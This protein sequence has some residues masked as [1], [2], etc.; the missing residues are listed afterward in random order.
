MIR[1]GL[2][3]LALVAGLIGTLWALWLTGRLI[4]REIGRR[5]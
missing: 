4:A 5:V 1:D 3:L 2:D